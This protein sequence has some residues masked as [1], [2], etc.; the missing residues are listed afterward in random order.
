MRNISV[1]FCSIHGVFRLQFGVGSVSLCSHQ[2]LGLLM[3]IYQSEKDMFQ[4]ALI[5]S[6]NESLYQCSSIG[7]RA[8]QLDF[9]MMLVRLNREELL[10]FLT[11]MW[12][13]FADLMQSVL[14]YSDTDPE[15]MTSSL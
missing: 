10:F 14:I 13:D 9:G 4:Q 15:P 12:R 7:R 2:I 6:I 5:F 1:D 11:L 8:F 3:N